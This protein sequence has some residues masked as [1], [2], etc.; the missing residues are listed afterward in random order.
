MPN[1][2]DVVTVA[3]REGVVAAAAAIQRVV[4]TAA[5]DTVVT[6]AAEQRIRLARADQGD[7]AE[8]ASIADRPAATAGRCG[9]ID[10]EARG[11]EVDRA[12]I[13]GRRGCGP[14]GAERGV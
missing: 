1:L 3:A 6:A 13:A 11:A 12:G 14:V 9:Q 10:I 5:A 8:I 4:A 2:V 7:G